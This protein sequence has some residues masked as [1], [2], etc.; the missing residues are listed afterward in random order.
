MK[1]KLIKAAALGLSFL[2]ASAFCACGEHGKDDS[3]DEDG[4][5]AFSGQPAIKTTGVDVNLAVGLGALVLVAA[6][7]GTSVVA[8]KKLKLF[9][10]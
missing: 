9:S 1:R 3:V 6:M 4:K 2:V 10:K 5:V 7:L 8:A